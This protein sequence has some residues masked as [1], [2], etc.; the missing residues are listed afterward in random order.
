MRAG[1][2]ADV[3]PAFCVRP[4]QPGGWTSQLGEAG[5][6]QHPERG[7]DA[8]DRQRSH[9]AMARREM[10]DP[11]RGDTAGYARQQGSRRTATG[12]I[13]GGQRSDQ[14]Y[15]VRVLSGRVC[16][17]TKDQA[18]TA[19]QPAIQTGA[20]PK[21]MDGPVPGERQRSVAR[22]S[23]GTLSNAVSTWSSELTFFLSRL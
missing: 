16:G 17:E 19:S 10:Q 4:G 22:L 8:A 3:E 12:R 6:E 15:F 14:V 9:G 20:G 23:G 1:V 11:A 2:P 13:D 5:A 7:G 21:P 18:H